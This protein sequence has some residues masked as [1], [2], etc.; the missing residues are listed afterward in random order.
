MVLRMFC[1]SGNGTTGT[2][3]TCTCCS[4]MSVEAS[5]SLTCAMPAPSQQIQVTT[6]STYSD[7]RKSLVGSQFTRLFCNQL[8]LSQSEL[9]KK[10]ERENKSSLFDSTKM[11]VPTPNLKFFDWNPFICDISVHCTYIFLKKVKVKAP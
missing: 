3:V 10:R 5:C 11:R 6:T 4:S 2:I 7:I 9:Y 8:V 1:L